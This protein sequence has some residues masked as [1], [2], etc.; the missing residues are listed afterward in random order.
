MC[1]GACDSVAGCGCLRRSGTGERPT[2]A[3]TT[4]DSNK[5]GTSPE[6]WNGK[7]RAMTPWLAPN[8]LGD[9]LVVVSPHPDDETLGVGGLIAEFAQS[10]KPVVVVSVTDGE[11]ASVATKN[12][13]GQRRRELSEAL[14]HLVPN[15]GLRS[16][17]LSLPDGGVALVQDRLEDA[18]AVEIRETDFVVAPLPCDGHSDHDSVG[19]ATRL[20][21]QRTGAAY[22]FYPIWAWHWH[23]PKDSV[24]STNGRRL[25]L[26][27]T[28]SA[29]KAAALKCFRSQT[30]GS[31]PVLPPHFLR[32]FAVP[33]EVMV[34]D[35]VTTD[36]RGLR[37]HPLG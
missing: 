20:I 15:G 12:L 3:F 36:S 13:R 5:P 16:V 17:R 1:I 33:H 22:R 23:D 9:R 27:S 6:A 28:A 21:A 11:A 24:I 32:R 10:N 2:V 25:D 18:L 4:V 7:V 8:D 19:C 34:N 31:Q 29:A 30:S 26:T 14:S 35:Y 37:A